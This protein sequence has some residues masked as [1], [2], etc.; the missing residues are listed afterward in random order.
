MMCN[1]QLWTRL[2]WAAVLV[3][4]LQGAPAT[5][6]DFERESFFFVG[7]ALVEFGPFGLDVYQARLLTGGSQERLIEL[8]Y[9]RD[10]PRYLSLK[11]WE[12]GF[13]HLQRDKD[14]SDAIDWILSNTPDFK[15]G[16]RF[17]MLT[18]G[19][20]THLFLNDQLLATTQ[21]PHVSE[22]I[23]DPWI[24]EQ[25]LD[26]DIKALLLGSVRDQKSTD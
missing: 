3:L 5:A 24:G 15:K 7:Q 2:W 18:V 12:K 8:E 17:T 26:A 6:W 14:G 11:G 13:S 10:V 25:A 4:G 22:I 16:D 20:M 19:T 21:D 9:L 1:R 23:H